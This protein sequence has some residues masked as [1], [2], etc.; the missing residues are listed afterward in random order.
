V[1]RCIALFT[2]GPDR[3][4]FLAAVLNNWSTV[5][6]PIHRP[7]FANFRHRS[8]PPC[9]LPTME[10]LTRPPCLGQGL[11]PS[12]SP[13][14][15]A[16]HRQRWDHRRD[17]HAFRR[18]GRRVPWHAYRFNDARA[19]AL[20]LALCSGRQGLRLVCGI[21][22]NPLLT[23][24]RRFD[25]TKPRDPGQVRMACGCWINAWILLHP[26]HGLP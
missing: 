6:G 18:R 16:P 22:Q 5:H 24:L 23:G 19:N 21:L 15:Q 9:V 13:A 26:I 12:R 2:M 1:R 17:R 14:P 20:L 11:R 8:G 4:G 25:A 3:P 7:L 10:R